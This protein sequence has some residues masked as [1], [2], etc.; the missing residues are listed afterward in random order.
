MTGERIY[1]QGVNH[2]ES[3]IVEQAARVTIDDEETWS[4]EVRLDD[5]KYTIVNEKS[6]IR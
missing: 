1:W 2:I 3:G 6:L 5:G 4:Y